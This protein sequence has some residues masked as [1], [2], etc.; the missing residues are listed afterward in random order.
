MVTVCDVTRCTYRYSCAYV[1]VAA[2][3]VQ[4]VCVSQ[5]QFVWCAGLYN[6]ETH[7]GA[8]QVFTAKM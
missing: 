3:Y 1:H 6:E 7:L 5:L 4:C 8:S 2:G